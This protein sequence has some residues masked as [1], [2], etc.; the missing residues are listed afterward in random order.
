MA[1]G[2]T[3]FNIGNGT[4]L[5]TPGANFSGT[6]SLSYGIFDG[7]DTVAAQATVTVDAVN[8]SP[9]LSIPAPG[10]DRGVNTYTANHQD[11]PSL[12]ALADGGW[13]AVWTSSG[14]DG[15]SLGV[16]AQRYDA[17]G[18]AAGG[19][20]QV[21]TF[22]A[23]SQREPQVAALEDGGY[24]VTWRSA[25]DGSSDGI[26]SQRYD[27]AGNAAG[28]ELQV[29]T[30]TAGSQDSGAVAGLAGGGHVV[31]WRSANQDGSGGGVYAQA[32]D[33][34]GNA[35]GGEVL[36][37]SE[38]AGDQDEPAVAALLDG[39]YVVTWTSDGEDGDGNGVYGQRF[40]A[41]GAAVGAEFRVNTYTAGAQD[42]PA[43]AALE[44]GGFVVAWRSYGQDGSNYGVYLQ[45]YDAG[46]NAAGSETLVNTH[47]FNNQLEPSVTGLAGGGYVVTWQSQY[48]DGSGRGVYAQIFDASGRAVGGEFRVTDVTASDQQKAVVIALADGGFVASWASLGQDG[49]GNGVFQRVFNADGSLRISTPTFV[50]DGAAVVVAAELQLG[51]ID[52]ATLAGASVAV[53][54]YVQGEDVLAFTA[55]AGISGSFDAQTGTLTL[56]GTAS[57]AEYQAV[58]RSVT[59]ANISDAPS[60][61]A[62][63]LSPPIS[64]TVDDGGSENSTS[65]PVSVTVEIV[66]VNDAPVVSGSVALETAEDTALIISEAE[67]LAQSSDPDGDALTRAEPHRRLRNSHRQR[68]RDV[69]VHP[70]GG[71]RRH[72]RAQL[73]GERRG[74]DRAGERKCRGG[75]R[76]TKRRCSTCQR[77]PVGTGR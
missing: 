11:S 12:A 25:G 74:A 17:D 57:V 34:G 72:C 35:L 3:L 32:Y 29:N 51:D 55:Q 75:T 8:D 43:I 5:F 76:R 42:D 64:F 47:T 49:D 67:L 2:G 31:V 54:D 16:F 22:T 30:Y 38:T 46:G 45:R 61:G 10:G 71:L 53:T 65:A 28:G 77:Q 39:G 69:D 52:S 48:Q 24:V 13:I 23:N 15:S 59:Y 58:L 18:N 63:G 26:F 37:N 27:A 70:G 6:V 14:Q 20:F 66:A 41:S 4:W 50:E 73:S 36:V 19:E 9:V 33:A 7:A 62:Q 60:A 68:Q 44:D 1:F 40:D 21:N 56:T